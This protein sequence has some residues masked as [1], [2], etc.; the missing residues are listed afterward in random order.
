MNYD[1]YLYEGAAFR[2]PQ[3]MRLPREVL[4]Q[5]Q[6][7]PYQDDDFTDIVWYGRKVDEATAMQYG[8]DAKPTAQGAPA[9][10]PAPTA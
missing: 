3:G 9:A 10:P 5:G 2:S 8:A 1:Y 4:S 6:W 7:Q